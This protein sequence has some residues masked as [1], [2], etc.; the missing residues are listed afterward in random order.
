MKLN[1]SQIKRLI[2]RY[3]DYHM[4]WP[5]QRVGQALYNVLLEVFPETAFN[6]A[7]SEIDPYYDNRNIIVM[8]KEI[9]DVDFT[10]H[11]NWEWIQQATKP[12]DE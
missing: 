8:F 6:V 4:N 5:E 3:Y 2:D 12:Q 1:E 9:T 11:D 7:G 10:K